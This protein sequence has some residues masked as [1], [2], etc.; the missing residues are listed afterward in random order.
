MIWKEIAYTMKCNKRNLLAVQL[1]NTRISARENDTSYV[2]LR[3]RACYK[4]LSPICCIDSI[5]TNSPFAIA[6]NITNIEWSHCFITCK[7][8][9][10]KLSLV[11]AFKISFEKHYLATHQNK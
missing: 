5:G 10:H 11:A 1:A 4:T 6:L 3:K 2:C 9:E 7:H 8:G